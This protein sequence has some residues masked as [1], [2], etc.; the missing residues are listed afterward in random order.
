MSVASS[1][2]VWAVTW[3]GTVLVRR[4]VSALDPTG[5]SWWEIGAPRPDTPLSMVSL[6]PSIVWC[7]GRDGSVWFRQGF[8]SSDTTNSDTLIKGRFRLI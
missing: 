7:V 1:G 4:G 5:V 3:H 2:L 6:G 8:K